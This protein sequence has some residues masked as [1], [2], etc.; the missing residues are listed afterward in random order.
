[1]EPPDPLADRLDDESVEAVISLGDDDAL[2]VTPTR[3]LVYRAEGL[4]RDESIAE[5]PHDVDRVT[6]SVG[7]RKATIGVAY[8]DG[9]REFTVPKDAVDDVLA[10][11][12]GGVLVAAG[13]AEAGE[14]VADVFRFSELTLIV[15]DRRVVKHVG[16]ALWDEEYETYDYEDVTDLAVEEGTVATQLVL[17]VEGR[18]RR[19]KAPSDR[20]RAVRRAIEA[21]LLAY[22]GIESIDDLPSPDDGEGEGEDEDEDGSATPSGDAEGEAAA[23]RAVEPLLDASDGE[24]AETEV[25]ADVG[26]DAGPEPATET[27]TDPGTADA[28][29]G[30]D[31]AGA[32]GGTDAPAAAGDERD[33]GDAAGAATTDV[34]AGT[35]PAA[36]DDTGRDAPDDAGG[37]R[38]G[39]SP[40]DDE[41]AARLTELTA[42]VERQNELLERQQETIQR[43]VEE[44]R[45]DR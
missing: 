42:A 34:D 19:I 18:P 8:L 15:T 31:G 37:F 26:A 25:E 1:M 36:G 16:A 5:Y 22:H 38:F 43:L 10:P 45:R 27:G 9:T 14:T 2:A 20:A 24:A 41:V 28:E 30:G 4:L 7:R 3:T 40:G 35:D 32:G 33:D 11:V 17:E 13:V 44:L 23:D 12:L 29:S 21:E 39:K 6:C